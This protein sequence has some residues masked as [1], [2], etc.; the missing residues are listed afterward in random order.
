VARA[1]APALKQQFNLATSAALLQK[2]SA[3]V[4]Q[5]PEWTDWTDTYS[6]LSLGNVLARTPDPHDQPAINPRYLAE[7]TDRR[8]MVGG[9]K[10]LR[11]LFAAP[12]MAKY[13]QEAHFSA[14]HARRQ[15]DAVDPANRTESKVSASS[16]PR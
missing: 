12:A 13:V 10:F 9:F 8:A 2:G 7:D 15:Y 11:R 1:I 14:A 6:H 16:T 3:A 4:A 5:L